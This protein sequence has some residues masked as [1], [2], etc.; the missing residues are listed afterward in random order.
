[1]RTI[2]DHMSRP[3]RIIEASASLA[4]ASERMAAEGLR[5]L[6]VVER[7]QPVGVL[8]VADIYRWEARKPIEPEVLSVAEAM[9]PDVYAVPSDT[10]LAQVAAEM[11][12]RRIGSTVVVVDG[13]EPIGMFTTVDALRALAA[14]AR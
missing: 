7:G 1:M 12:E 9:T 8:S 14:L 4:E 10:P 2:A 13:G 11:A 3:V 6:V 5:H